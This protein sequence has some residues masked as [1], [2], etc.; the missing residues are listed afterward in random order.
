MH[1]V[2]RCYGASD[3]LARRQRRAAKSFR[4]GEWTS[5]RTSSRIFLRVNRRH[6]DSEIEKGRFWNLVKN[7]GRA[8]FWDITM[9]HTTQSPS[10]RLWTRRKCPSG[11]WNTS[12]SMRCCII[13]HPAR[14]INGRPLLSTRRRFAAEEKSYPRYGQAQ[15]WLD[16]VIRTRQVLR[17]RGGGGGGRPE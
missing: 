8:A 11:S 13:K 3:F 2:L 16:R 4:P 9:L 14:I 5:L 7:E 17:A 1:T 15:E 12:C 6:F 10:A